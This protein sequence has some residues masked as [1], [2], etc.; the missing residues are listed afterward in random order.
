IRECPVCMECSLEQ[1][2]DFPTHDVFIG[3][4]RET[5]AWE[6][7]ITGGDVDIS[8]VKP[9]LFD[10]NSKKYWALGGERGNCWSAGKQLKKG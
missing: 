4:V 10:M 5:Y 9:L 3:Q 7:V 6:E 2:V 1:V 8:K